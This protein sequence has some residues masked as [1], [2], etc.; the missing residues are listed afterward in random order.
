MIG[1]CGSY[2]PGESTEQQLQIIVT[3]FQG[4]GLWGNITAAHFAPDG[5]N[6][7]HSALGNEACISPGLPRPL[8]TPSPELLKQPEAANG[9]S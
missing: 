8:H 6:V 2:S 5:Q 1:G 7:V 9:R 4:C 3:G